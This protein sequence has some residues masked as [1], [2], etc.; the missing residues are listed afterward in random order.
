VTIQPRDDSET[1]LRVSKKTRIHSLLRWPAQR[2]FASP[3]TK[4]VTLNVFSRPV[5]LQRSIFC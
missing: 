4:A 3:R 1:A 5:L 2:K